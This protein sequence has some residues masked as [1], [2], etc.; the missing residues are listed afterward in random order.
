MANT[1]IFAITQLENKTL[2]S[3]QTETSEYAQQALQDHKFN[4]P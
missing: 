2:I 4:S 3:Q 1:L